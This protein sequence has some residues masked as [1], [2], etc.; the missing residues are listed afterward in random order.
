M[1]TLEGINK[2]D[3]TNCIT[4]DQF[5]QYAIDVK[6]YSGE[7]VEEIFAEIRTFGTGIQEYL[8]Q[9]ELEECVAFNA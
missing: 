2:R 6:G 8:S 3:M 7:M 4:K 5:R 9:E 1:E